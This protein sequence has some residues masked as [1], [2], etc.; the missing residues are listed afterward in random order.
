LF[1]CLG[2]LPNILQIVNNDTRLTALSMA[3]K[4]ADLTET[5]EQP[6]SYT[7]FAP[8]DAAF[9][10]LPPEVVER[11]SDPA[12]KNE[13][14]QAL[15]YHAI[16]DKALTSTDLIGLNLPASLQT[17]SGDF[18]TV[19][20]EGDQVKINDATVIEAD[21]LASNGVV[22]IIDAVLIPTLSKK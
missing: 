4:A 17:L 13:L 10:K 7:L 9:S 22:H 12:N 3:L 6:G 21:I 5:S 2:E 14:I 15:A 20:K 11:L 1:N 16:A 19:T 18:I 8:T